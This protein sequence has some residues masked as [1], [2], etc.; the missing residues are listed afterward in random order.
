[1]NKLEGPNL[2][3]PNLENNMF[4]ALSRYSGRGESLALATIIETL[5]STY[6]KAGARMLIDAEGRYFGLLGGGCFEGDL[7]VHAHAVIKSAGACIVNYDLRAGSEAVWGLGLGCNGAVHILLQRL[8]PDNNYQPA[9]F[10]SS[11][12]DAGRDAYVAS[13]ISCD[14]K[15][16]AGKT[17]C[18][19]ENQAIYCSELDDSLNEAVSGYLRKNLANQDFALIDCGRYSVYCERVARPR[20][21]LLLGGGPDAQPLAYMALSLGWHVTICDHRPAY[22]DDW[23]T[24][25]GLY[26]AA[27]GNGTLPGTINPDEFD[28]VLVM[29]HHFDTDLRYL[30][31]LVDSRAHYIGVLGPA[32]RKNLLLDALDGAA[33]ASL[34]KRLFGPVGLDIGGTTPETIAL[35]ALSEI[36][37]VL[38][39]GR[40]GHLGAPLAAPNHDKRRA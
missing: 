33:A 36:H 19:D 11:Q 13:I 16:M 6:R 30:R 24:G 4:A 26:V 5:G 2:E 35:S 1:M 8:S 14:E 29:S 10:L 9:N 37:S 20:R 22:L 3:N 32:H 38:E 31:Q 21:M 23:S 27:T 7:V 25:T 34:E 15:N 17:M 18:L 28:A 39:N 12:R 40:C